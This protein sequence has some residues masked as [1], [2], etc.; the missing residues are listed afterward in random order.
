MIGAGYFIHWII[1]MM[2]LAISFA[3]VFVLSP[4]DAVALSGSVRG[5]KIP[6]R[7]KRC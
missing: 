5:V 2:P 1:P 3:L 7:V 6:S 4:T